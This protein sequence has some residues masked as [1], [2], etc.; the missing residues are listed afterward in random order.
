MKITKVEWRNFTSYGNKIQS[1]D[2]S[3]DPLLY[4]IVGENGAGK[5]SISQVIMFALYGKVEGKKLKDI[6]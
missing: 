6:P 4:Q 2:L 5:T 1:L 3:G